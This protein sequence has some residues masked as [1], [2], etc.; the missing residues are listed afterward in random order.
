MTWRDEQTG[1]QVNLSS[2]YTPPTGTMNTVTTA[3]WGSGPGTGQ[4]KPLDGIGIAYLAHA[5][6][7][8]HQPD[9]AEMQCILTGDRPFCD[10]VQDQANADIGIQGNSERNF[11]TAQGLNGH[12]YSAVFGPSPQVRILAW[13]ERDLSNADWLTP[14]FL[15]D[16][17]TANPRKATLKRC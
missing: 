12:A 13:E 3:G 9:F 8:N 10:A 16:G 11:T 15:A 4:I 17:V 14:D 2:F 7:V 1:R 6:E 5:A